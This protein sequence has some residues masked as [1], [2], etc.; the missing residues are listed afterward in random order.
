MKLRITTTN[1]TTF[2]LDVPDDFNF[3]AFMQS[4]MAQ[5]YWALN[6]VFVPYHS[7]SSIVLM[8]AEA[9]KSEEPIMRG[10]MQ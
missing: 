4:V 1:Q 3:G 8:D 2:D 10:T 6:K 9:Q 5:G 7:M